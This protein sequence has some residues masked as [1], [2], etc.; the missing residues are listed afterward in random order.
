MLMPRALLDGE[1]GEVVKKVR[2]TLAQA[3]RLQ[4][5]A[6]RIGATESDV[7]RRGV[8]LVANAAERE[9]GL[10]R[11]LKMADQDAHYLRKRG[12]RAGG[13]R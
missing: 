10:Q 12:W 8:D 3:K 13:F 11:L 9:A 4:R 2:M 1:G 7:L 6:D 5:L